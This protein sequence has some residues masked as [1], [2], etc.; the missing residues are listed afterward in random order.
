MI[1]SIQPDPADRV[2]HGIPGEAPDPA[3]A[4]GLLFHAAFLLAQSHYDIA[5]PEPSDLNEV[6][7]EMLGSVHRTRKGL[8]GTR[9]PRQGYDFTVYD[10]AGTPAV[11]PEDGRFFAHLCD[12]A[13]EEWSAFFNGLLRRNTDNA[14]KVD[15][16]VLDTNSQ[17]LHT[18]YTRL[19]PAA[20]PR[21]PDPALVEYRLDEQTRTGGRK[22]DSVLGVDRREPIVLEI[23]TS[24]T[25]PEPDGLDVWRKQSPPEARRLARDAQLLADDLRRPVRQAVLFL[26]GKTQR[27]MYEVDKVATQPSHRPEG[28][29]AN[30]LRR[31]IWLR[32]DDL[33]WLEEFTPTWVDPSL[34]T[35]R[36]RGAGR[37]P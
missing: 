32:A 27:G 22:L 36:R 28:E 35:S 7:D 11:M 9:Q 16:S 4:A 18:A 29:L 19:H 5:F 6:L 14:W 8:A 15:L 2:L 24:M 30:V 33:A 23:K 13:G 34:L 37:Q 1:N 26:S 31:R 21:A 25:F 20:A 17:R 12:T 3:N 10:T